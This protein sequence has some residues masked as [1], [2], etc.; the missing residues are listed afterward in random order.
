MLLTLGLALTLAPPACSPVLDGDQILG[1]H[2]ASVDERYKAVPAEMVIGLAPVP[3]IR[4]T[5]LPHTLR[6]L[7]QTYGSD[8]PEIQPICLEWP[9]RQL[10]PSDLQTAIGESLGTPS[11][12]IEVL[13]FTKAKVPVGNLVFPTS[14]LS[15]EEALF[16]GG[17]VW[18]GNVLLPGGKKFQIWTRV[19]L[20]GST[21]RVVATNEIA[22]G[23]KLDATN[24]VMQ[25]VKA[26][27]APAGELQSLQD[28]EGLIARR[29]I[30][31]GEVIK[32]FMLDIPV[33][34]SKG[35]LL[36]VRLAR[37]AVRFK[38]SAKALTSGRAGEWI[39]LEN[40]ETG[41]RYRGR[42]EGPGKVEIP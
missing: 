28:G 16:E 9:A 42:I 14:G 40:P 30:R 22:V 21:A 4:R 24:I 17:A 27:P 5:V 31:R 2:L 1:R 36:Q 19:K 13:D 38:T 25:A 33:A 15:G 18:R 7:L 35:D 39:M 12:E 10:T 3:G 29:T 6:K 20:S 11:L 23:Q 8:E 37:G 26:L 41:K 32:R 34:I